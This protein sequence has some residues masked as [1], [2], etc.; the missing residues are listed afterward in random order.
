MADSAPSV[1]PPRSEEHT[2]EL[3]PKD[4]ATR[5]NRKHETPNI[6]GLLPGARFLG[7]QQSGRATYDV[8]VVLQNVDLSKAFLCGY[9]KILGL[10]DEFPELT[11][12]FEGEIVG[13][14]HSFIT[15]KWDADET[16]DR[17]VCTLE[18]KACMHGKC[19]TL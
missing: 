4:A 17:E 5:Q 13:E 16:T 6:R 11:T 15:Q 18:Q 7:V 9:L 14:R 19:H 3:E 1:Q 12:Y 8:E 2:A 10:T